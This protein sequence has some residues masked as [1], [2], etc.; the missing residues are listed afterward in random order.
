MFYLTAL[1]LLVVSLISSQLAV[2]SCSCVWSP[3][4]RLAS[5][6][7]LEPPVSE[8]PPYIR[9]KQADIKNSWGINSGLF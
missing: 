5:L 9:L 7:D 4:F 1:S 8:P 6:F 3:F 2:F